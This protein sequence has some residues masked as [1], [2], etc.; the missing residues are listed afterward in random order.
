MQGPPSGGRRRRYRQELSTL[1]AVVACTYLAGA[2]DARPE[3]NAQRALPAFERLVSCF[4]GE[5]TLEPAA[6]ASLS[7]RAQPPEARRLSAVLE[8]LAFFDVRLHT[9]LAVL[10]LEAELWAHPFLATLCADTAPTLADATRTIDAAVAAWPDSRFADFLAVAAV[11]QARSTLLAATGTAAGMAELQR[12]KQGEGTDSEEWT[13][14]LRIALQ[15]WH[16]APR[17]VGRICTV[18]LDDEGASLAAF[19]GATGVKRAVLEEDVLAGSGGTEAVAERGRR[20]QRRLLRLEQRQRARLLA[21]N[22]APLLRLGD[23]E[24]DEG[25]HHAVRH[26]PSQFDPLAVRA[27]PRASLADVALFLL[28]AQRMAG[29]LSTPSASV[30]GSGCA[31]VLID[32]GGLA[33]LEAAAGRGGDAALAVAASAAEWARDAREELEACAIRIVLRGSG[34]SGGSVVDGAARSRS[35]AVAAAVRVLLRDRLRI[36]S[37]P[38]LARSLLSGRA[39]AY[40]PPKQQSLGLHSAASTPRKDPGEDEAEAAAAQFVEFRSPRRVVIVAPTSARRF[41]VE[42]GIGLGGGGPGRGGGALLGMQCPLLLEAGRRGAIVVVCNA[43]AGTEEE[44]R[45]VRDVLWSCGI[46]LLLAL[47]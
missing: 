32:L 17:G 33:A 11:V 14:V 24:D 5:L 31:A 46:G 34:S 41:G 23:E 16:W 29:P 43:G 44:L 6:A 28:D 20:R 15:M 26:E 25:G 37:A 7:P 9:H 45:L 13:R 36:R 3:A 22:D 19:A 40:A 38:A 8:V 35:V 10:G 4:L 30:G 18:G 27:L 39:T 21:G 2:V 42:Q 47:S 1:A 12:L